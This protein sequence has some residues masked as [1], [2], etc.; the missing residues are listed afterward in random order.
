MCTLQLSARSR[1]TGIE[2]G[3][4]NPP[5]CVRENLLAGLLL[6]CFVTLRT[7]DGNKRE[8]EII[9][10]GTVL[11][12]GLDRGSRLVQSIESEIRQGHYR[13][14]PR[15]IG[16]EPELLLAVRQRL[17]ELAE[18]QVGTSE[19]V[20]WGGVAGVA[21][22]VQLPRGQFLLKLAGSA[23]V[24]RLDVE[25]LAL[26]GP[27]ATV[28]GL[29]Q[30]LLPQFQLIQVGKDSSQAAVGKSEI[31]V[32]LDGAFVVWDGGQVLAGHHVS[33]ISVSE[34]LEGLQRGRGGL[35]QRLV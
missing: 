8:R 10:A 21:A 4:V 9:S 12:A 5:L 34:S 29:L 6:A 23:V 1:L 26:A 19:I 11:P 22:M 24:V 33:G 7:C 20:E 27:L 15:V 16:I 25:T 14:A 28:H 2:P 18:R 3:K 30:I 17:F 35:L 13:I 31:R 32:Q